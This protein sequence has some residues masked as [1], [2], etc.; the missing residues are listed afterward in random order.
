MVVMAAVLT[1]FAAGDTEAALADRA[2]LDPLSIPYTYYATAES[3]PAEQQP[4]LI[5]TFKF[6]VS[7]LSRDTNLDDHLPQRVTDTLY[8]LD[9]RALKW[10][11]AL[12]ANLI[13]RYPYA[14]AQ[15]RYKVAPLVFR[16]DWFTAN[17]LDE[18]VTGDMQ[19]ELLY[20]KTLANESDFLKAWNFG[21]KATDAFGF[22]E[23]QSG[24]K[25]QGAGLERVAESRPVG[26][27]AG[28][29]TFD[30]KAVAGETDPLENL[31]SRP[32][33]HDASEI[34]APILKVGRGD[35]GTVQAGSLLAYFLANGN[36]QGVEGQRQPAAPVSIVEDSFGL[37]GYDIRNTLDCASCHD[38]GL[39]RPN[40]DGYQAAIVGG[41]V[42]K[43]LKDRDARDIDRYYQSAFVRD[44]ER[45]IEDYTVAIKLV[46]GLTP[47]E[48]ARNLRAVVIGYDA[49]VTRQQAAR[50][51]GCTVQ[52]LSLA[53]AYYVEAYKGNNLRMAKLAEG[54]RISRAQ[55]EANFYKLQQALALWRSL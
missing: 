54:Q 47:Q 22:L 16:M 43:A 13:K 39:K 33:K 50:E 41:V 6:A 23:D 12:P 1:L 2:R 9:T 52:E 55:F 36:R 4:A 5:A 30:S 53:V 42:V 8:R 20:G 17:A 27:G 45:G 11:T 24:V 38:E 48:N 10:E 7:S 34:I 32:P 37:R 44:V 3:C 46:T 19:Y 15:T 26:R 35:D 29:Q 18:V 49:D 51:L 40:I 31:T 25:R 14:P 28:F 21:T